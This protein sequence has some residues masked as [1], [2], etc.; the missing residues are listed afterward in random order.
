MCCPLTR[1]INPVLPNQQAPDI[2]RWALAAFASVGGT[3][4]PRIDFL[5]NEAT[6]EIWLKLR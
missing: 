3:G 5:C 2:R 1:D 4:A 6:G